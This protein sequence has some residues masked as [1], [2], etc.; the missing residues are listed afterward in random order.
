[1]TTHTPTATPLAIRPAALAAA[2]SG[3]GVLA[4]GIHQQHGL[5]RLL[6]RLDRDRRVISLPLTPRDLAQL[7]P[8]AA[9]P[10]SSVVRWLTRPLP[11]RVREVGSGLAFS[12]ITA[13]RT[14][15]GDA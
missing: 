1:M 9:H 12:G 3:T 7:L 4:V 2:P 13:G 8:L 6:L 10:G 14:A 15:L 11:V 5:H